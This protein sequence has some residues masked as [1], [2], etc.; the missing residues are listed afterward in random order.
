[1]EISDNGPGIPPQYHSK[2]FEKFVRA[3]PDTMLDSQGLGLGLNISHKIVGKLN[4][5]LELTTG[6]LPGVCFRIVLPVWQEAEPA[7]A[8]QER[9]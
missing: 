4:G 2:I 6:A 9:L 1:V 3:D 8:V 5:R 7:L